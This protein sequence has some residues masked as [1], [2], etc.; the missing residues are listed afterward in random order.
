M[1]KYP[2][3]ALF[4]GSKPLPTGLFHNKINA[5]FIGPAK[6]KR[7]VIRSIYLNITHPIIKINTL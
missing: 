6:D 2:E 7:P 3:V 5:L 1:L 4:T